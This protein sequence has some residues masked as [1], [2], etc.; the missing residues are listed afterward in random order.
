M[1]KSQREALKELAMTFA[2]NREQAPEAATD[3]EIVE[4]FRPRPA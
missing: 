1:V 4:G 3:R 2:T